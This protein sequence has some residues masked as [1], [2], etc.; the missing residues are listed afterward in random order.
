M[1]A[2]IGWF[3]GASSARGQAG[4]GCLI[5]KGFCQVTGPA[6]GVLSSS[7]SLAQVPRENR[8]T[9][10]HEDEAENGHTPLLH[11]ASHETSPGSR[12]GKQHLLLD[13]R[14]KTV[15]WSRAWMW[16]GIENW[17]HFCNQPTIA[18]TLDIS[19][20]KSSECLKCVFY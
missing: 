2:A 8:S 16:G 1:W 4:S 5:W 15:T 10:P 19:P 6:P 7:S 18:T 17:G 20:Y 14:S 3:S 12:A 11:V 13:G 9:E